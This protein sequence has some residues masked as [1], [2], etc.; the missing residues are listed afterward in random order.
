MAR[1]SL[2]YKYTTPK[3]QANKHTKVT[4][5]KSAT[6]AGITLNFILN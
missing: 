6:V 1:F 3:M 2:L 5:K 4:I